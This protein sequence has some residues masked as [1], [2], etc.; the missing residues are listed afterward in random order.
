MRNAKRD[1]ELNSLLGLLHR[2]HCITGS[3]LATTACMVLAQKEPKMWGEIW[4]L[5]RYCEESDVTGEFSPRICLKRREI[6]AE[7]RGSQWHVLIGLGR[8]RFRWCRLA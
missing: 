2:K 5:S 4:H 8:Y 3:L 7:M 6:A 1:T